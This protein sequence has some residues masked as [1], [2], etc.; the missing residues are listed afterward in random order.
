MALLLNGPFTTMGNLN[1][2]CN[3]T[4]MVQV[5]FGL[6]TIEMVIG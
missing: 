3:L 1:A 6:A 2:L 5:T 4:L